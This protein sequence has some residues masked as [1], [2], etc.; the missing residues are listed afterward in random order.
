MKSNDI[1]EIDRANSNSNSS[2]N[3]GRNRSAGK[4]PKNRKPSS[5][6]RIAAS[7]ANG[8]K[9]KGPV[10]EAGKAKSSQNARDHGACAAI[11]TLSPEE[12]ELYGKI[13]ELYMARLQPRDQVEYDLVEQIVFCNY[14]MRQVWARETAVL[15]LQMTI[16]RET[17]DMEWTNPQFVSRQALAYIESLKESNALPLLQR[18]ARSLSTQA[19]RTLKTLMDLRKHRLPPAVKPDPVQ[20]EVG[21]RIE[22]SPK[23]ERPEDEA[24][25]TPAASVESAPE[26]CVAPELPLESVFQPLEHEQVSW[27]AFATRPDFEK[28]PRING[29]EPKLKV[30]TAGSGFAF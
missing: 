13:H 16:D 15:G 3:G 4:A 17:V 23:I 11:V 9:S 26:P 24:C 14:R 5:A 18:Y 2:S 7:R 19:E 25:E 22:P 27:F 6:R 29:S 8:A 30:M 28:I 1:I 10:S 20:L 12:E 21:E